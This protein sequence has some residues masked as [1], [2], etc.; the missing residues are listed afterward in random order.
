MTWKA[1]A[2]LAVLSGAITPAQAD[3]VADFYRGRNISMVIGYTAGGGYDLY[4]RLLA[5]HISKFIPGKPTV[6]PQNMPGAGSLKAANYIYSLAPK[7]GA[8]IGT[9]ARSMA[10]DPL[11]GES[12]FDPREFTWI[13]S[14]TSETSVCAMWETSPVKRWDDMFGKTFTMGGSAPGSE[15]D[16]FTLLLKNVFG[17]NVRLVTGYP[18]GNDINLAIERGE[19]DGRC[20]WSWSSIKSQRPGWIK[21]KKISLLVQLAMTKNPDLGEVPLLL[22]FAKDEEQRQIVRLVLASLVV[23]R[24]F[25]APPGVPLDRKMALRK[26][27]DDTMKDPAFREE[28]AKLDLEIEPVTAATIDELL[29]ELYRTPRSVV[30]KAVAAVQK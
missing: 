11:L 13:G 7:D 25:F 14:T 18:G 2:L 23:G 21:D 12:K 19:V 6:V 8:T 16:V 1:V 9:V 30:A 10:T 24:P 20:G 5:R 4:A 17:A 28:A 15:P 27:F 26:A 22:D 3:D 29:A